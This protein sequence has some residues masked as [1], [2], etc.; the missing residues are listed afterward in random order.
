MGYLR[1]I[2]ELKIV[3]RKTSNFILSELVYDGK[4]ITVLKSKHH[5]TIDDFLISRGE[6]IDNFYSRM[7]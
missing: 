7:V 3:E 6:V 4:T 5:L 1:F 2:S